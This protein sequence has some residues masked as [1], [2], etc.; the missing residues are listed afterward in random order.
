MKPTFEDLIRKAEEAHFSGW[1]FSWLNDRLAEDPLPWDYRRILLDYLPSAAA[2]LDMGTGGGEFLSALP[3]RPANTHA[4]ESYPPN[5]KLAK[6]RLEP[7]G[8]RVHPI[9]DDHNLPLPKDSFDL[10]INRHESYHPQEIHRILKPGGIFITQQVGGEDNLAL[11]HFLAPNIGLEYGDWYLK[12]AVTGL[13]QAGLQV[14]MQQEAKPEN[15]FLDI[16]AVV[17]YL[18]VIEWQIPGFDVEKAR[19]RLYAMHQDIDKNGY[20]AANYHRFILV[21][22]KAA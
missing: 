10:V 11:N 16:G 4:T 8:I 20:F 1:D 13:T 7:L 21:A 15:R 5:I 18:K 12:K 17:Y 2:L 6:E 22:K 9:A 19:D 3:N 14:L